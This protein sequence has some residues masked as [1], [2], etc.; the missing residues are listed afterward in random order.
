MAPV[1]FRPLLL[2]LA[3]LPLLATAGW[4]ALG[5]W[6]EAPH[7]GVRLIASIDDTGVPHAAIEIA[8]DPGWKTY[9]REPGEGGLAPSFDFSGSVNLTDATVGFP[10]PERYDDGFSVTNV[11]E[12]RLLLPI[13]LEPTV[14]GAPITLRVAMEIGVCE[15]VCIP[16]NL[17]AEV[18][19]A[20]ADFDPQ[21]ASI[22]QLATARLPG[23]PRDGAFAVEDLERLGEESGLVGFTATLVVPRPEAE[24]FIEAP[25]GWYPMVAYPVAVDGDRVTFA[26]MLERTDQDAPLVGTELRLTAVSGREAIEQTIVVE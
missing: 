5:I 3:A 21:V 10:A 9:W 8:L 7:V 17:Q 19:I 26:F 4:A 24:L 1:S 6:S 15:T 22:I 18:A 16:T 25:P 12:D 14:G 11:Y 2:A 20:P 13:T 23:P